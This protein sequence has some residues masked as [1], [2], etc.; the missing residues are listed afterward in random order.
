[1]NYLLSIALAF[2]LII[3]ILV[4]IVVMPNPNVATLED[5]CDV[6]IFASGCNTSKYCLD[7]IG[8]INCDSVCETNW[9]GRGGMEWCTEYICSKPNSFIN[10]I[11]VSDTYLCHCEHLSFL[12]GIPANLCSESMCDKDKCLS[13]LD[14]DMITPYKIS[15]VGDKLILG[16]QPWTL[17]SDPNDET[18]LYSKPPV[19]PMYSTEWINDYRGEHYGYKDTIASKLNKNVKLLSEG[20]LE[21]VWSGTDQVLDETTY[22]W[23]MH[24]YNGTLKGNENFEAYAYVFSYNWFTHL[25]MNQDLQAQY[26][27]FSDGSF[28]FGQSNPSSLG[29]WK[30]TDY[31][32]LVVPMA[33]TTNGLMARIYPYPREGTFSINNSPALTSNGGALSFQFINGS[34][35]QLWLF[36][37]KQ[38]TPFIYPFFDLL[39]KV[40]EEYIAD[41]D[42]KEAVLWTRDG[43]LASN[44]ADVNQILTAHKSVYRWRFDGNLSLWKFFYSSQC[45]SPPRE[46]NNVETCSN[47]FQPSAVTIAMNE[48]WENV[49]VVLTISGDVATLTGPMWIQ[50]SSYEYLAPVCA[51]TRDADTALNF[52]P[53]VDFLFSPDFSTIKVRLDGL[54][55]GD[56][57]YNDYVDENSEIGIRSVNNPTLSV[58]K[59]ATFEVDTRYYVCRDFK[60]GEF[61]C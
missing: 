52:Y 58:E 39:T 45:C 28:E 5:G 19:V 57:K 49:P 32:W 60:T 42:I 41:I 20:Y 10:G 26:S 23:N 9:Q 13:T 53:K 56:G 38:P 61:I 33:K 47:T 34:S 44:F 6:S 48:D 3:I 51:H 37:E 36:E 30:P 46:G 12:D 15:N 24:E 8:D 11:H 14:G 54:Y 7:H 2:V 18:S 17:H 35:N 16:I 40:D 31:V 50:R 22:M 55:V 21:K 59:S 29:N 4:V 1:M 27:H 25:C 43:F